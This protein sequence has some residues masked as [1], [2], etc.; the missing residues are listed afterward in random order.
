MFCDVII[1]AIMEF[2]EKMEGQIK[3]HIKAKHSTKYQEKAT[4]K[5]EFIA[6]ST[7]LVFQ[8]FYRQGCQ[9][10]PFRLIPQNLFLKILVVRQF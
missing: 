6:S 3:P 5:T 1:S 4:Y 9:I 10:P 2:L 8:F 7:F